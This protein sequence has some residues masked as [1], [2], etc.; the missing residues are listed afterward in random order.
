[1][2]TEGYCPASSAMLTPCNIWAGSPAA[3]GGAE[4]HSPQDPWLGVWRHCAA[5]QL[6]AF[7]LHRGCHQH[8][9]V[10]HGA[11]GLPQSKMPRTSPAGYSTG[12]AGILVALSHQSSGS[13]LAL[14]PLKQHAMVPVVYSTVQISAGLPR[15][16][17]P[18]VLI[19]QAAEAVH[20]TGR[21]LEWPEQFSLLCSK[22]HG[23]QA[24]RLISHCP[25]AAVCDE[26]CSWSPGTALCSQAASAEGFVRQHADQCGGAYGL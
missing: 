22:Q 14:Y 8:P 2:E 4:D 3:G 15:Q 9:A 18:A 21:L 16:A 13:R 20:C 25:A 12:C 11:A 1:M 10:G 19:G 7:S 26:A 5:V 23:R 6:T 17:C 24:C